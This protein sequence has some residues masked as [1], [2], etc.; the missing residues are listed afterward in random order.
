MKPV[1]SN[2]GGEMINI[3]K[4]IATLN[5][6]AGILARKYKYGNGQCA[7]Y[8]K[9]AL[10]AG[11]ASSA[12][13]DINAAKDYGA[14]LESIGFEV[15]KSAT[16]VNTGGVYSVSSQRAGD[17]VVIQNAPGHQYGHMTMFNGTSWVS[18][19]IQN[20]GFYPAQVYRDQNT[21]YVLYHYK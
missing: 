7:K 8:V 18:D 12:G 13:S 15:D 4:A 2:N 19:Y 11:G 9:A 5:K 21:K 10:I 17:V 3:E 6:N 20:K 1:T 16:T 14:W